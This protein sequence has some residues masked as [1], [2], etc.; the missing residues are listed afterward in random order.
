MTETDSPYLSPFR[1]KKNE[2]EFVVEAVKKIASIKGFTVEEVSNN[3]FM[4]YQE[5]FS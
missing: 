4:N 3:I 5:L 2:P 1:G